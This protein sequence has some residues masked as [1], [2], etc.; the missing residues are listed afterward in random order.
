MVRLQGDLNPTLKSTKAAPP[1]R[2]KGFAEMVPS[3]MP[4]PKDLE[5]KKVSGLKL[6]RKDHRQ[7]ESLVATG[8]GDCG[9]GA[10]H[11]AQKLRWLQPMG[12]VCQERFG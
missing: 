12:Q 8:E 5:R 1:V 10:A 4:G 7:T 3:G 2:K 11:T 9:R 6:C